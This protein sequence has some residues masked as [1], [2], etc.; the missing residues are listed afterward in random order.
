MVRPSDHSQLF[1]TAD[2][3]K[4]AYIIRD[5]KIANLLSEP[6]YEYLIDHGRKIKRKDI[7]RHDLSLLGKSSGDFMAHLNRNIGQ[8]L[9]SYEQAMDENL[10]LVP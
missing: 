9:G 10:S 2:I 6:E 8:A 3:T 7:S 1:R 4:H 5:D